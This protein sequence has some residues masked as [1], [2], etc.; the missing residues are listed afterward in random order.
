[1]TSYL[2]RSDLDTLYNRSPNLGLVAE[3]G[4]YIKLTES[5]KWISIIDEVELE[6]WM[7]QV[8]QLIASKVE[9]LPG[10]HMEVE[11]CTIRFHPGKSF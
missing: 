9:R 6:G 11:D 8:S 10:S 3:N 2:K 1:M 5:D 7:P 4:G